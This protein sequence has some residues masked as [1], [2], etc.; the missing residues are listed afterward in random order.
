MTSRTTGKGCE[1][2]TSNFQ[3]HQKSCNWHM[4]IQPTIPNP[5][6]ICITMWELLPVKKPTSSGAL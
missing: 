2:V 4:V 6:E 1:E 5:F 3:F